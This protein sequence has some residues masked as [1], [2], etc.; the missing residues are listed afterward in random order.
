MDDQLGMV[1]CE[2]CEKTGLDD[3][4]WN[5]WTEENGKSYFVCDNCFRS[6]RSFW[7]ELFSLCQISGVGTVQLTPDLLSTA[8]DMQALQI[9]ERQE[10]N[11]DYRDEQYEKLS[12]NFVH[13]SLKPG[14]IR[15]LCVLPGEGDIC[16]TIEDIDLDLAEGKYEALSYSW[17][18]PK[19]PKD[20]IWINGHPFE[21]LHNL[22]GAITEL[23]K[24]TSRRKLWIDAICIN[25]VEDERNTE[26]SQQIPMMGRIY[27]QAASVVIWLGVAADDSDAIFDAIA[28]QDLETI[29][30]LKFGLGFGKL[31]ERSWWRRTWIVQE[32]VLG[33]TMPQ[34]MCGS[35]SISSANFLAMHWVL[36]ELIQ[37]MEVVQTHR[38]LDSDGN[39]TASI[40]HNIKP[41]IVWRNHDEAEKTLADLIAIRRSILDDES[42]FRPRP[43]YKVLPFI[44]AFNATNLKDKIYGTFGIVSSTVHQHIQVNYEKLTADV[45]RDVMTYM[46]YQDPDEAQDEPGVLDMYLEFPLSGWIENPTPGLPS[47]V[48]DFSYNNPFIRNQEDIT[49]YWLYHQNSSTQ[50]HTP[51]VWKQHGR[52]AVTRNMMDK[53]LIAVDDTRLIAQGFLVDEVDSIVGSTFCNIGGEDLRIY[54]E[55]LLKTS[56]EANKSEG[57]FI[58]S[59]L[60]AHAQ[61]DDPTI[62]EIIIRPGDIPPSYVIGLMWFYRINCLYHID[63]LCREKLSTSNDHL[64]SDR[65]LTFIWKDLLEGHSGV[66]GISDE[67][68]DKQFYDLAGGRDPIKGQDWHEKYKK[69]E[70]ELKLF[71]EVNVSMNALFKPLR[72]FFTTT[73]HSFY[74]IS[75][76]GIEEKDKLVFLFPPVY[77][78]FILRPCG[79]NY[80]MVGPCIVPPKLRDRVL[81]LLSSSKHVPDKFVIV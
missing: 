64:D 5:K 22:Y 80:K 68:F 10:S 43:L 54:S 21:V 25:Q 76:P 4:E 46:L 55:K 49:W 66:G 71:A 33:R 12:G 28:T 6:P 16:C 72:S 81:E 1:S 39:V 51:E 29:K 7:K 3:Y 40:Q 77:M 2:T 56:S 18:D 73:T 24:D 79:E 70:V 41:K 17:G 38:Y 48:P 52:H 30:T 35:R 36:P 60:E 61:T 65:W 14:H 34:I 59:L 67:E 37:F 8:S 53:N 78:A 19:Q 26:R 9:I 47:W 11:D 75:P 57:E 13:T 63:K 23:R 27:H 44:K 20:I 45:Y 42:R 58:K 15:L 50:S 31:L 69:G 62:R 32:F 74:G